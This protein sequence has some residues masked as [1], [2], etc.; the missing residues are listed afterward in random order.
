MDR[1]GGESWTVTCTLACNGFSLTT[2]NA[3]PDTGASGYLFISRDMA[4]KA[5]KYL[6]P[7]RV[8]NFPPSPVAG[9]EGEATQ[10]I[11]VALVMNFK[12]DCLEL[13]NVP[14]FVINMKHDLILGRNWFEQH[15]VIIDCREK[16]FFVPKLANS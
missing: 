7:Q 10:L 5:L 14:F 15:G 6:R 11:D 1:L 13:I 12:I 3:L 8:T 9:F 2:S 16:Q 4:K